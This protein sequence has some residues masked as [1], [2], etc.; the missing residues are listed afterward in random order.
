[1]VIGRVIHFSV[2]YKNETIYNY[3]CDIG[4]RKS[5]YTDQYNNITVNSPF[6]PDVLVDRLGFGVLVHE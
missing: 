5:V 4:L 2:R 3:V 1:M 6:D